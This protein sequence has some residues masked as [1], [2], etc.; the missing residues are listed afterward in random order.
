MALLEV[1]SLSVDIGRGPDAPRVLDNVTFE[2]GVRESVGLVGES[3]CGKSM[4]ALAI[5]G[6]LPPTAQLSGSIR[7]EGRE[8]AGLDDAEMSN[9]RGRRL[10]MVFQ[11]PMSA[12][13]PVRTIGDQVAEGP[14]RHLGLGRRAARRRAGELLAR[15]G[16]PADRVSPD[17]YPHELSGGQRQRVVIAIALS[18]QPALL[19]ADEPTTALDVTT[20]AQILDLIV[21]LTAEEGMA[22]IMITHDL[23]VVAEMTDRMFVMYAGLVVERGATRDVFAKMAH[24]YSDGLFAAMPSADLVARRK[25]DRLV[26]IPGQVPAPMPIGQRRGCPFSPRCRNV[27]PRCTSAMPPPMVI[28]PGHEALCFFPVSR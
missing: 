22:L 25:R 3:G 27:Q 13:N 4:T 18:S 20:Q 6:L 10:A 5:L 1:F 2:V 14:R 9:L 21:E 24:P 7:F 12:L 17:T 16:L 8:L 11:E 19:I 23:G 26:A 15:V 28:S